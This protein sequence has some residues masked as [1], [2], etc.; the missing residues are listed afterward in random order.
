MIDLHCG[1][2][3][4]GKTPPLFLVCK[5][6][7]MC[8]AVTVTAVGYYAAFVYCRKQEMWYVMQ[9]TDFFYFIDHDVMV[10]VMM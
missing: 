4:L 6:K 7:L 2:E 10:D 9:T 8:Q 5:L 1:I 3:F